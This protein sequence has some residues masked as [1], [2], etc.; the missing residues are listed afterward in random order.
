MILGLMGGK[1]G[2]S[3]RPVA[4]KSAACNCLSQIVSKGM[5]SSLKVKLV[6]SIAEVLDRAGLI[7]VPEVG[8]FFN[9]L[10]FILAISIIELSL[11][12]FCGRVTAETK[13]TNTSSHLQSWSAASAI[14]SLN[15]GKSN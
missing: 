5:D 15:A 10:Y 1:S 8:D 14:N 11:D 2:S 4:V 12:Y 13:K 3:I 6:E 7:C 9:V